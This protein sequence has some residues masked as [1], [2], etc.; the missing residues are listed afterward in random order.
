MNI[1]LSEYSANGCSD[2][3]HSAVLHSSNSN[4]NTRLFLKYFDNFS[5]LIYTL[6]INTE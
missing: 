5:K 1:G 4:F 2:K 3:E 6:P